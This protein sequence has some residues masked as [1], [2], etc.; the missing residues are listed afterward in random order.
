M[1][2]SSTSLRAAH[3]SFRGRYQN[4]HK[5]GSEGRAAKLTRVFAVAKCDADRILNVL[6]R[7]LAAS[8][9][10]FPPPRNSQPVSAGIHADDRKTALSG[11]NGLRRDGVTVT[12]LTDEDGPLDPNTVHQN[13]H[14]A[15]TR[16]E[17]RNS[18]PS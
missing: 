18:Y 15:R 3:A 11:G 13:G 16:D 2:G 17:N 6:T 7:T 8:G 5:Q 12:R 9:D 1:S 10:I 4:R 14:P